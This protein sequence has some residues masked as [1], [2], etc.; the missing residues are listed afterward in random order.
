MIDFCVLQLLYTRHHSFVV[1]IY[2]FIYSVC[3]LSVDCIEKAIQTLNEVQTD[4]AL[5]RFAVV[6][7]A[8]VM[9]DVHPFPLYYG[10]PRR[11]RRSGLLLTLNP[12]EIPG[13]APAI[14]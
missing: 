12:F 14:T 9:S 8:S 7:F 6:A 3:G 10:E 11:D 13:V 5:L 4:T 1:L 2:L